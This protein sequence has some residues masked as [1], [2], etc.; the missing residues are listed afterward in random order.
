MPVTS[1]I[2]NQCNADVT[3]RPYT[4]RKSKNKQTSTHNGER[5][6]KFSFVSVWCCRCVSTNTIR[7]FVAISTRI[8]HN[9]MKTRRRT[10]G[11]GCEVFV[12]IDRLAGSVNAHIVCASERIVMTAFML[13]YWPVC[14][15]VNV[16]LSLY[17]KA[18]RVSSNG[19]FDWGRGYTRG[20]VPEFKYF[21]VI[22]TKIYVL[23]QILQ[24]ALKLV[25]E[26]SY[27][28]AAMRSR[29]LHRSIARTCNFD[30]SAFSPA[31]AKWKMPEH[32]TNAQPT[33]HCVRFETCQ[34]LQ[35]SSMGMRKRY[36]MVLRRCRLSK[37][38]YWDWKDSTA[39]LL[40]T[41]AQSSEKSSRNDSW[42]AFTYSLRFLGT[43][44]VVSHA[45]MQ[46]VAEF[47]HGVRI[48]AFWERGIFPR[49]RATK[50]FVRIDLL[51]SYYLLGSYHLPKW[52]SCQGVQ[53]P[54][55]QMALSW[56][57][58][59]VRDDDEAMDFCSYIFIEK[60]SLSKWI[61]QNNKNWLQ[62]E[63][64]AQM[65]KFFAIVTMNTRPGRNSL[66]ISTSRVA[67]FSVS[68]KQSQDRAVELQNTTK[69]SLF[70]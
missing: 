4:T 33:Y 50:W 46:T 23:G 16:R 3:V 43:E 60:N 14:R 48:P 32:K 53:D 35:R 8:F 38:S 29:N 57:L 18:L 59:P 27:M 69:C 5:T 42:N 68:G 21:P 20:D 39:P 55:Y 11:V 52:L 28:R 56:L 6:S 12:A 36:S 26:I 47:P 51:G 58:A 10:K 62:K 7:F 41:L 34:S 19:C 15:G 13:G 70:E 54:L 67:A 1:K 40:Q 22:H 37:E 17:S 64:S 24:H 63:W 45:A 65:H 31:T 2:W 9:A 61:A 49:R 44:P 25:K 66:M 30:T